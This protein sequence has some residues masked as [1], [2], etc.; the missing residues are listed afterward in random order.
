M[1]RS[2]IFRLDL[3]VIVQGQ[4]RGVQRGF[5]Q[6]THEANLSAWSKVLKELGY[7]DVL[8]LVV[9][10]PRKDVPAQSQSLSGRASQ[11]L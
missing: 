6:V 9:E 1:V 3:H 7:M 5:Q 11:S 10:L 4:E 8:L 2:I